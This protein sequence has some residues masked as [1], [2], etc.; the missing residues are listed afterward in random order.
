MSPTNDLL[1]ENESEI[2]EQLFPP[3]K[4]KTKKLKFQIGDFVRITIKRQEFR[5]GYSPNF[6]K[7]IFK[8]LDILNT[9]PVTYKIKDLDDKE[10]IG[11]FYEPELVKTKQERK[12]I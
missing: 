8:I 12:N 10:I 1:K 6:T 9:N 11:S 3:I 4:L 2:Y 7:E 5:Q